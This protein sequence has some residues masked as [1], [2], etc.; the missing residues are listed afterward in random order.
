MRKCILAVAGL[1][2]A[3]AGAA[4]AEATVLAK[5]EIVV[6]N[7]VGALVGGVSEIMAVCGGDES[8]NGIDGIAFDVPP[9]LRGTGAKL[10]TVGDTAL[11]ADVYWYDSGCN[12]IE[13]YAM[14]E[15]AVVNEN[16]TVP[17]EAVFGVV[18]LV[19]GAQADVTLTA[20][21]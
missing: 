18:D 13:D 10:V 20:G 2:A 11:D 7:P 12:L 14:A 4:H 1:S 17:A 16:G 6:G 3:L 5:G 15:V 21:L 9:T 19:L 8:F